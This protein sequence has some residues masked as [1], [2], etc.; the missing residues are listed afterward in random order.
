MNAKLIH[1]TSLV[2]ALGS[3]MTSEA[4]AEIVGW[5]KCNEGSGTIARDASRYGNDVSFHGNPQWVAGHFNGGLQ[6][7]GSGD[8]LD[9]EVYAPSLDIAGALTV[10]AWV[11]PGVV[12]RD[13]EICGNVTAG[14]D[15]GGYMLGIYSN[16]RVEL[17][18][19]SSAGTSAPANRP[20]G[21]VALQAGAWY[22]PRG[23]L[24]PDRRRGYHQD[25]CQWCV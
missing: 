8:Y 19:W 22:F 3:I 15:G 6:F 5:W 9:R 7:D 25:L 10:T 2:L 21:G 4:S 23:D 1:S 11:K 20:G 14:P 24:F 16:D 18:V 13:H 12:L 17:E